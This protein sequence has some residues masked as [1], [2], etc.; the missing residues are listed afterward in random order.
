MLASLLTAAALCGP[1]STV[2]AAAGPAP[3]SR[4]APG[5]DEEPCPGGEPKPCGA[6]PKERDSVE[7]DRKDVTKDIGKANGDISDAKKQIAEC[8]PDSKTC[9]T[10]LAGSGTEE[11]KGMDETR[12]GLD[13]FKPAP[14]DNAGGVVKGAC[15]AFAAELPAV[16]AAP[17][18]G[19]S[20]LTGVCELMNP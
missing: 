1:A 6:A 11:H 14:A 8:R 4:P 10:G 20:E 19:S 3:H 18:G 17:G 13:A 15:P 12:K 2:V 7:T 5:D 16:F 9:M